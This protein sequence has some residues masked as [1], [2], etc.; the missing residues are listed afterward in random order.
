MVKKHIISLI[1][2]ILLATP[3]MAE[4]KFHRF[5]T[6]Q[7]VSDRKWFNHID[8]AGTIGTSGLGFDVAFP[9]SEWAQL[10]VGGVW[11]PYIH[12]DPTFGIEVAEDLPKEIQGNRFNQIADKLQGI[13]G[14]RPELSVQMEGDV[15][16]SNF[17]CLV[18]IFPIKKNRNFHVTVGFYYGNTDFITAVVSPYSMRNMTAIGALNSLYRKAL[19][20][21]DGIIIDVEEMGVTLPEGISFE[22]TNKELRKW[23]EKHGNTVK[24]WD[25]LYGREVENKVYSE[26]A[27]NVAIGQ[28][29]HDIVA[30]EDIYYD[31]TAELD[32]P[33]NVQIGT[34]KQGNPIYRE[35][36]YQTDENGRPIVK[37]GIRYHKGE[38]MHKSG[39]PIRMAPDENN[40]ISVSG[41][42]WWKIKPFVGV[43]YSVPITK[44]RRTTLG[45]DAGVTIW[46]G[47][48]AIDVKVPLGQDATG[49]PVYNT[50]NLVKDAKSMPGSV[51][52]YV[53]LVKLLPVMPEISIRI[54]QRLW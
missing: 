38:L 42:G 46:G 16:M 2:C 18:D 31:Y 30:K 3:A 37:G 7:S 13:L 23:G 32:N 53:K 43:G 10:R 14:T 1:S 17:K 4:G 45:I 35:V 49:N 33:Y 22:N 28:Y 8:V 51:D 54:A 48:P 19:G 27:F 40:Q 20:D 34:D 11:M 29:S 9:M 21:K 47:T 26:N 6:T 15:N 12:F 41:R 44:D 50:V 24:N 36:K 25:E 52:R 39:D 5:L